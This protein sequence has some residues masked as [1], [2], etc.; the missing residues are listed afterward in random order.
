MWAWERVKRGPFPERKWMCPSPSPLR[1]PA[2]YSICRVA[3]GT[4]IT[5]FQG[6][7]RLQGEGKHLS[8]AQAAMA[9]T[10]H[11]PVAASSLFASPRLDQNTSKLICF[12][13]IILRSVLPL[14]CGKCTDSPCKPLS[15]L[16]EPS[17]PCWWP[18]QTCFLPDAAYPWWG[19][20]S[21][22]PENTCSEVR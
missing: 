21:T 14:S 22:S 16:R 11:S 5:R 12:P 18:W 17:A 6:W 7:W 9:K 4:V 3:S 8:I 20:P 10:V 13:G 1:C 2:V 19:L 15:F